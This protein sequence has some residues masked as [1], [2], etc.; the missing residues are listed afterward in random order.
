VWGRRPRLR[1][2]STS[3][4]CRTSRS[5][6]VLEDCPTIIPK[7]NGILQNLN[8]NVICTLRMAFAAAG[9]PNCALFT[10]VFQVVYVT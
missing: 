7:F 6:A 5:R 3:R 2:T 8:R 4:D 1:G 9:N 10:V